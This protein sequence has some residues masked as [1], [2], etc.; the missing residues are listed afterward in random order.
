M[1]KT[2]ET[3]S[4]VP[5]K[6]I[7]PGSNVM[8][9]RKCRRYYRQG[10]PNLLVLDD[11]RS[12]PLMNNGYLSEP[13]SPI[14]SAGINPKQEAKYQTLLQ[15]PTESPFFFA[16]FLDITHVISS[17]FQYPATCFKSGTAGGCCFFFTYQ[18]GHF[19]LRGDFIRYSGR[20]HCPPSYMMCAVEGFKK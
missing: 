17:Q 7:S 16:S 15:A 4:G 1:L 6:I 10:I 13:G 3:P 5:V 18:N 2:R 20:I 14:V 12:F 11:C 9:S 8:N 19:Q